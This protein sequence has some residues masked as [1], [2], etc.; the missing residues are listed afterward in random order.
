MSTQTGTCKIHVLFHWFPHPAASS[1]NSNLIICGY[2][3]TARAS[4]TAQLGPKPRSAAYRRQRHLIYYYSLTNVFL[5]N[6]GRQIKDW[7]QD[8]QQGC[9]NNWF[10]SSVA[11]LE[12][13]IVYND[14]KCFLA[15]FLIT[16]KHRVRMCCFSFP[17]QPGPEDFQPIHR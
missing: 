6:L 15:V 12:K 14:P 9:R 17:Q 2:F 3:I 13:K 1:Q 5:C 11:K 8:L 7:T 10:F 4:K 16:M